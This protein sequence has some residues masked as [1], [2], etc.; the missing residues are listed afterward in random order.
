MSSLSVSRNV[1][2]AFLLAGLL[3]VGYDAAQSFA[4]QRIVNTSFGALWLATHAASFDAAK[5]FIQREM[6][7]LVW[8]PIAQTLLH[9]PAG[10]LL[11]LLGAGSYLGGRVFTRPHA[12]PDRNQDK[13]RPS[14]ATT[15]RY[16]SANERSELAEALRSCRGAFLGV[17]LFSGISNVLMLT[18]SIYMLQVYDRVLPSR[19][20]PTLIALTLLAVGLFCAQGFFDV[21]RARILVRVGAALDEAL[22]ARV[23][24]VIVRQPLVLGARDSGGAPLQDL[25][26]IRAFLSNQGPIALFDL[27]WIPLYLAVIFAFHTWLGVAALGGALF[28]VA[29]TLLAEV[30][31]RRPARAA[32][33]LAVSRNGMVDA[34]RRNAD[35]LGAMGMVN[36]MAH[37]WDSTNR[38]YIAAQQRASDISG[39]LGAISRAS[40]ML[41]QSGILGI[42]AYLVI[43]QEASAGVIIAG[44]ILVGRALAPVDLAIAN[45]RGFVAARQSWRRLNKLLAFLPTRH[46]PMQLPAPARVLSVEQASA[47]PPGEGKLVVQDATF[48]LKAGEALGI[49]GPSGSGKSSLARLLVGAWAPGKGKVE[50]D[51]ATLNQ[52][53][54]EALGHHIGYLPQGSEVLAGTVAENISRFDPSADANAIVKAAHAAAVHNLIVGLPLGYETFIGDG[55]F[56]LSVGQRQRIGLARAVF[57]DPFLVVLDEP[58]ANL[59]REGELA[60]QQAIRSVRTRGGIVVVV[61]HRQSMLAEVDWVLALAQ[62][63]TVAFGPRDVVLQKLLRPPGSTLEPYKFVPSVVQLKP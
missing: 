12:V 50:L 18:G 4:S 3:T 14:V 19:G 32:M 45:W 51:G 48:V 6:H 27:P 15:A 24:E 44:A 2:I 55:G 21:I 37:R 9:L 5:L 31:S 11:A 47:A 23:Y 56:A 62:G 16:T 30:L 33:A 41:L 60:L 35:M 46:A 63:R 59:D 61:T 54:V 43:R 20:V 36:R 28:L 13:Q 1:S 58:D 38:G 26:N 53:P 7:A 29:L 34:G 57:G 8:D 42:G 17:A 40:R 52:W 39:G 25:D 49:I 22:N 10:L